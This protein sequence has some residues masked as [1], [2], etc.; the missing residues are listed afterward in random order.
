VGGGAASIERR[1]SSERPRPS[2]RIGAPRR[3]STDSAAI[4][5]YHAAR[6]RACSAHDALPATLI[7]ACSARAPSRVAGAEQILLSTSD[8]A[9]L[10]VPH[11]LRRFHGAH[12]YTSCVYTPIGMVALVLQE[13]KER[14]LASAAYFGFYCDMAATDAEVVAALA[15]ATAEH[16]AAVTS[17]KLRILVSEAGNARTQLPLTPRPTR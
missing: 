7:V 11:E 4:T 10:A 9:A 14:L 6:T 16:D 1:R 3:R 12:L 8:S 17:L 15:R 13:H 5:L 2:E